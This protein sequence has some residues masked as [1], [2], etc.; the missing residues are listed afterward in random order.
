[1][2]GYD[3]IDEKVIDAAPATVWQ[4]VLAEFEGAHRW[5]T[6]WVTFEPGDIPVDH[7]GG[8]T[9]ATIHTKGEHKGGPRLRF[10]A[11]TR[12]VDPGRELVADYVEGAFR[13]SATFT[14]AP[15]DG[16]GTVMTMRWQARPHGFVKVLAKLKDISKEHA[17]TTADALDRLAL[18]ARRLDADAPATTTTGAR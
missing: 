14:V 15:A 10:T 7:V 6:P 1:M 18:Y 3:I 13:G 4:A 8:E 17:R 9:R 11:R 5:W 16:G 2:A 12:S